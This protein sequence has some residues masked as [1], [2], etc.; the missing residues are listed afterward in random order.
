MPFSLDTFPE[1]QLTRTDCPPAVGRDSVSSFPIPTAPNGL[2]LL[3]VSASIHFPVQHG[4]AFFFLHVPPPPRC[5]GPRR[6]LRVV[7]DRFFL[8]FLFFDFVQ[9]PAGF[10]LAPL[11]LLLAT[12]LFWEGSRDCCRP[13]DSQ[14]FLN[15]ETV[16]LGAALL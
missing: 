7:Q 6:S 5:R 3:A 2:E 11:R 4:R 1:N 8:F 14:Q 9:L 16:P 12:C 15:V 13:S 10:L